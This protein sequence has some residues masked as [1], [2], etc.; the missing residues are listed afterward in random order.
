MF[1][2]LVGHIYGEESNEFSCLDGETISLM[3]GSTEE[4]TSNQLVRILG[5]ERAACTLAQ[6]VHSTA[7]LDLDIPSCSLSTDQLAIWIDPIDS[8]AEYIAGGS[9]ES[10]VAGVYCSGLPCVTV[11]IGAFDRLSGSPVLGVVNQP[12]SHQ[13]QSPD[14][15]EGNIVWDISV[16]PS[17]PRLAES[18][19]SKL[20]VLSS[21]E[22]VEVKSRLTAG[23]FKLIEA[24]G[25]G[26]K[27]LC[28][29]KRLVSAYVLSKSSTF[30]WDTCGIQAV[31]LARGGG[32]VS[33]L[34]ALRGEI[35]PLT[36]QG[37]RGTE[38]CCNEGGLIAYSDPKVLEEILMLLK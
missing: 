25:A 3:V 7:E 16:S 38:Q 26:Y 2:N 10:E 11:L 32:V 8:T 18:Q 19:G 6:L 29:A 28:V 36:Y 4:E 33:Y 9:V 22:S 12:F 24:A 27:L 20:V 13:L 37:G 17:I 31:L 23:G 30:Y 21:S 1:Q 14:R 15:W 5:D 34:D 35:K